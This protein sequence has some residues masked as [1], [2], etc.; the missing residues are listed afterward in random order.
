MVEVPANA[1]RQGK[2]IKDMQERKRNK[3]VPISLFCVIIIGHD[4]LCR[5]PNEDTHTH[6]LRI[7]EFSKVSHWIQDNHTKINCISTY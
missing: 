2:E 6:T 4:C 1:I 5:Q 7:R 3:M